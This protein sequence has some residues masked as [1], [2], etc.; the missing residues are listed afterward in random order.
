M[1]EGASLLQVAG[2]QYCSPAC[3]LCLRLVHHRHVLNVLSSFASSL[4]AHHLT[5]VALLAQHRQQVGCGLLWHACNGCCLAAACIRSAAAVQHSCAILRAQP[6]CPHITMSSRQ[7]LN[8]NLAGVPHRAPAG[9][10]PAQPAGHGARPAAARQVGSALRC[11]RIANGVA[12][13]QAHTCYPCTCLLLR[14]GQAAPVG[15]HAP[16]R[17]N[18]AIAA[19]VCKPSGAFIAG[20]L[21][22]CSVVGGISSL[23]RHVERLFLLVLLHPATAAAGGSAEAAQGVAFMAMLFSLVWAVSCAFVAFLDV[24]AYLH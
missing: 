4:D 5:H 19:G 20:L 14:C 9:R 16:W 1:P 11:C 24:P 15:K 2:C 17:G 10:V 6:S 18:A 21:C 12:V 13:E 8:T 23:Q 22:P 3:L 7:P